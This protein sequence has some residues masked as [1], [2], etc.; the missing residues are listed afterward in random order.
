MIPTIF[1]P[2]NRNVPRRYAVDVYKRQ[3]IASPAPKRPANRPAPASAQRRA[4]RSEQ[5]RQT[6]APITPASLHK[7]AADTAASTRR[8]TA[9]THSTTANTPTRPHAVK[10]KLQHPSEQPHPLLCFFRYF[11]L[12]NA[13]ALFHP[14][15]RS[16]PGR[17]GFPRVPL[18]APC[19]ACTAGG[20]ARAPTPH[21]CG[22]A[23]A[24]PSGTIPVQTKA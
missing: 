11:I 4:L 5:P 21:P 20:T 6:K 12:S 23:H 17:R 18:A 14:F 10:H 13:W 2:K 19:I 16:G 22:R 7:T 3:P 8:A 9:G 24:V 15:L 1:C